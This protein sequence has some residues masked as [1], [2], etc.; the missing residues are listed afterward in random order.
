MGSKYYWY[1]V[2]LSIGSIL[3]RKNNFLFKFDFIPVT[4]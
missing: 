4:W 1:I 2:L 3:R